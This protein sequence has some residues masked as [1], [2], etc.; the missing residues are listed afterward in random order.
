MLRYLQQ[1]L[2]AEVGAAGLQQLAA[3]KVLV[4]GAGG[5]G[6]PLSVYL[7]AAGIGTL[8]IVDGDMVEM[9][10]LARQ[11]AYTGAD[12]G[13]L[14]T[15]VLTQRLAAQNPDVSIQ[16]HPFML[17]DSNAGP[18]F[19]DFDIICDCT[20]N[21]AAHLLCDA[22][23]SELRKPLVYAV[24]RDWQG[25]VTVLHHTKAIGLSQVFD[26]DSLLQAES[27]NCAVAGII[28]T[29]CGIAGSLQ[30]TEVIKI[31]LKLPSELDGGILAFNSLVPAFRIFQLQQ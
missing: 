27:D 11:F 9:S 25:Y 14:K 26:A 12:I 30:A 22:V 18:L 23:C 15:E 8:G 24:V 3:A 19:A 6:I 20:D 29:T 7:A 31:V 1:A 21:A 5:L 16:V 2:V 13:R 10:N 17:S 28:N 4:V